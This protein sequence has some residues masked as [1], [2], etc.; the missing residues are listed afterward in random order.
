MKIQ[1]IKA[2]Q[3]GPRQLLF[4]FDDHLQDMQN[5]VVACI[6]KMSEIHGQV[7]INHGVEY[8]F[9]KYGWAQKDI[10][11]S[12]F[13]AANELEL[14]LRFAGNTITT[15]EAKEYL[16]QS[17]ENSV[18][19]VTNKNVKQ[20]VFQETILFYKT[21]FNEDKQEYGDDQ[22]QFALSLLSNFN[23][24]RE[25]LKSYREIAQKPFYPGINEIKCHLQS[26]EML[27]D[28]KDSYSLISNCCLHQKVILK[29]AEDVA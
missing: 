5:H 12:I 23:K 20:S 27:L 18:E 17:F 7:Y 8:A 21:I 15:F 1:E 26:L 24:W 16:V 6:K 13:W 25:K 19:I 29:I 4:G 10:L 28:K 14:H 2:V 22:Y 9:E 11:Q 3:I